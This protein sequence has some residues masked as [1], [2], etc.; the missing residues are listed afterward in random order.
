MQA[1][2]GLEVYLHSFFTIALD[3]VEWFSFMTWPKRDWVDPRAGLEVLEKR[4]NLVHA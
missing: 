4:K 1:H 2:R 3:G